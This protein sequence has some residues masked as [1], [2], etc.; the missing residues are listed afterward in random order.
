LAVLLAVGRLQR[1]YYRLC[2]LSAALDSGLLARL[3]DGPVTFEQLATEFAPDP[4]HRDGLRAWLDFGVR[5][6]E[7][8]EH[9]GRYALRSWLGRRLASSAHD[10]AAALV[11]EA[12]DLHHK[13]LTE[14]LTRL[15]TG[16][17]FSLADQRGEIIARSSRVLEPF[18]FDAIDAVIPSDR[19]VCLLE[20]GCGTG[21]Y[22]RYALARNP[23]M[24]AVG[25]ELQPEVAELA[26]EN[27]HRWGL[28]ERVLVE[29]GDVRARSAK[30]T[31]DIVT[32][33]NNIYYFPVADRPVLLAH[34]RRFLRAGGRL[35]ITTAC[36]GGS[37]GAEILNVWAAMTTG[38][39]RLPTPNEL[40]GQLVDAGYVNVHT[41]RLIPGE[42]YYSFVGESPA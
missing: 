27:L 39:G 35:L 23:R 29:A 30:P 21:T 11:Q 13:L 5:V 28:S 41:R 1:S 36:A 17:P 34:L 19:P 31:F 40:T 10:A 6:R 4:A 8:R 38:C 12:G 7:L 24:T 14:G 22:I 26:R 25:L 2:F 18:V 9:A 32:L 42:M 15:R 3:A 37:P 16:R 20:I 33:H